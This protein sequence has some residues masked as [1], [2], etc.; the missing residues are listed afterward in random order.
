M[1]TLKGAHIYLRALEPEDIH[2]LYAI[3]NDEHLWELSSTQI[4]YSRYILEQYLENS[5][6]DLYEVKQLRLVISNY[7]HKAIGLIDLFDFDF[8]NSHAGVGILIREPGDR[9]QG[10]GKEALQLLVNYSFNHLNLHQLYCNITEGNQASMNLFT[11]QGFEVVGVKKDWLFSN[12]V[13][14]NEY[15]LQLINK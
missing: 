10:F 6:R 12:K 4:P 13:Y 15:L 2:F 11:N 1:E 5:H 8:Q 3:E 7:Q 14:K 9:R